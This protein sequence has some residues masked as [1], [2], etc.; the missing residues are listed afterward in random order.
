M[1][2]LTTAGIQDVTRHEAL[3][4]FLSKFIAANPKA[5][6]VFKSLTDDPRVMRRL[7]AL[8]KDEPAAL[9]QLVD[10]EERLAYIYQFAMAGLLKL[11]HT[12]GTTLMHKIRKFLR[13]VFQMISDQERAVDL[14]YAFE[15]GDLRTPNAAAR[16]IAKNL[17]Q[18]TWMTKGARIS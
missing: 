10:G 18:G 1:S 2:T 17:D 11:P 3:H 8:L 4:A 15:R 13:R 6:N 5:V 9:E 7:E 14:L 12:P 16:V